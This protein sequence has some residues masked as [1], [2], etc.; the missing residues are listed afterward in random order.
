VE[1]IL[2]L[3]QVLE[4]LTKPEEQIRESSRNSS[5]PP[6]QDPPRSCA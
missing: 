2:E 4:Q 1:F 6:S 5:K 3:A